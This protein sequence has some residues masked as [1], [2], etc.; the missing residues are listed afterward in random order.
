MSVYE[1]AMFRGSRPTA[2]PAMPAGGQEELAQAAN[3]ALDRGIT[4]VMANMARGVKDAEN[5]EQAMNAF[6][7]DEQPISARREE[8]GGIVGMKDAKKTPESVLTLVQPVME[9]RG[10]RQR[11]SVDEGIGQ[12]AQRAMDTPVEGAM[13]GG[14]MEQPVRM[15]AG[16]SPTLASLYQKNLPT[17]QSIYGDNTEEARRQALGQLLLGGIAPT[18]LAIAQGQPISEALMQLGP[19]AAQ[20][21][22]GVQEQQRKQEAATK[23][24]ALSLASDELQ[25]QRAAAAKAAE[26]LKLAPGEK[27]FGPEDPMTGNRPIVAE[28]PVK[29]PGVGAVKEYVFTGANAIDIPGWGTIQPNQ[30]IQIGANELPTV[31]E[32]LGGNLQESEKPTAGVG[33]VTEY[34]FTGANAIDIPGYGTIQPNQR[35]QIGA[36]ELPTVRDALGGNLQKYEKPTTPSFTAQTLYKPKDDGTHESVFVT[37]AEEAKTAQKLGFTE[38]SRPDGITADKFN[39]YI[40]DGEQVLLGDREL[41]AMTPAER[42]ALKAVPKQEG[43]GQLQDV[44]FRTG[45]FIAGQFRPAGTTF[46]MFDTEIEELGAESRAQMIDPP[47][48]ADIKVLYKRDEFGNLQSKAVYNPADYQ[49]AVTLGFTPQ[50]PEK[51]QFV[52]MVSVDGDKVTTKTARTF[53]EQNKLL[54]QGFRPYSEEYRT[55]GNKMLKITP[56]GT[57]VVLS[58][59]DPATLFNDAGEARVV[60]S[61]DEALAA[62]NAGFH[63]TSAPK[64]KNFTPGYA[65][66]RLLELVP[67][68]STGSATDTELNEFQT[69]ISVIKDT[70]RITTGPG[71]EGLVTAGGTLPP[72]VVE[73]VRRAKALDPDFND[74]G[75]LEVTEEG[76]V[77]EAPVYE[78]FIDPTI[79][80]AENIGPRAKIARLTGNVVNFVKGLVV[81]ADYTPVYKENFEAIDDLKTL[82]TV[83]VTRALGAIAGKEAEGLRKRLDELQVVPTAAG[84]SKSKLLSSTGN[85]LSF[86]KDLRTTLEGQRDRAP[87]ATIRAKKRD[88]IDQMDYLISQYSILERNLKSQAGSSGSV[89]DPRGAP[90][91]VPK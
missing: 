34:V 48:M 23:Q 19:Y 30:R 86:L 21:G 14:I 89:V 66:V 69:A 6:R 31:R 59:A 38:D 36:N 22:A 75:L 8:L 60:K 61:N 4:G 47:K 85:M 82:N 63:F 20:L 90:P 2:R 79:N 9:M 46:K 73:A 35:I 5:Y 43:R 45:Q 37:N 41:D 91:L 53:A 3:S 18:G 58:E 52:Q 50:T 10:M 13:A 26:L 12:I 87:T 84:L 56:A 77:A 51:F 1:R 17:I 15:Q 40:K 88:D 32:A 70:P 81:G 83:T 16:G 27:A 64:I 33:T 44:T 55:L 65:N 7:G 62:R 39:F 11:T 42:K 68:I 67:K 24:A 74:M 29:P 57:N 78:G 54:A 76:D 80:Y 71:G 28:V 25:A 72:F 49:S